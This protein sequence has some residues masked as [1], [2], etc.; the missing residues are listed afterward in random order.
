MADKTKPTTQELIKDELIFAHSFNELKARVDD[1]IKRRCRYR[2]ISNYASEKYNFENTPEADLQITIDY[3]NKI[4]EPMQQIHPKKIGFDDKM[5]EDGTLLKFKKDD[6]IPSLNILLTY[7]AACELD[8]MIANS[9]TNH[10]EKQCT[11]MCVSGCWNSCSGCGSCG[12][13][14]NYA[15]DGGSS[16]SGGGAVCNPCT[17]AGGCGNS[18]TDDCVTGCLKSAQGCECATCASSA[19][20]ASCDKV[21]SYSCKGNGYG[22]GT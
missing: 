7:L 5:S 11:G 19:G 2:D 16:G 20:S 13:C 4:L 8:T 15:G 1:E 3:I 10:C 22:G 9:P 12:G 6:T 18:C 17:R 14:A 21:C